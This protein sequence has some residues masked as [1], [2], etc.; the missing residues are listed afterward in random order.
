LAK[1][2]QLF[3]QEKSFN[4]SVTNYSETNFPS[5]FMVQNLM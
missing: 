5:F 4:S 3:F 2:S 1:I